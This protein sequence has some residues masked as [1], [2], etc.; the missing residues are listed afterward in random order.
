MK[1]KFAILLVLVLTLSVCAFSLA[2]CDEE[3]QVDLFEKYNGQSYLGIYNYG[4]TD[5]EVWDDEY[6]RY[7][8]YTRQLSFDE[9][10]DDGNFVLN[11]EG[12]D[13]KPFNELLLLTQSLLKQT[14]LQINVERYLTTFSGTLGSIA[15]EL[16]VKG[17]FGEYLRLRPTDEQ[18]A[19]IN[20]E[21]YND[22]ELIKLAVHD[23][24]PPEVAIPLK[25]VFEGIRGEERTYRLTLCFELRYT[26]D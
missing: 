5:V 14:G 11:Y 22:L 25:L 21:D 16:D 15:S 23:T 4:S 12:G 1:K 17:R 6:G 18:R 20:F 13:G 8:R 26:S 2:A 24:Y 3:E 19:G 9:F 10:A 7:Y